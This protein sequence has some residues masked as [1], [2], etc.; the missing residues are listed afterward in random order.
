M[1][2]ASTVAA[3]ERKCLIW[4]VSKGFARV[5]ASR[6]RSQATSPRDCPENGLLEK[7]WPFPAWAILQWRPPRHPSLPAFGSSELRMRDLVVCALLTVGVQ[8]HPPPLKRALVM[9]RSASPPLRDPW[10]ASMLVPRR[11]A[12][13]HCGGP[14]SSRQQAPCAPALL[15]RCQVG[16]PLEP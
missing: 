4:Y 2:Y 12:P 14:R 6:P 3:D 8:S 13:H 1:T 7:A 11:S 16:S 9:C 5:G 15:V 10:C